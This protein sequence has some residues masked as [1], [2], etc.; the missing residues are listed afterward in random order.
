MLV[1]KSALIYF[2]L[3]YHLLYLLFVKVACIVI[4]IDYSAGYGSA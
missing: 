4:I 2:N 3:I 1:C